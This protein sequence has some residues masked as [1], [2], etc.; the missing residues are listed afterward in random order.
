MVYNIVV[1]CSSVKI[2]LGD[3]NDEQ[4]D[5]GPTADNIIL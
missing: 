3:N 5:G 4:L 2:E 1:A